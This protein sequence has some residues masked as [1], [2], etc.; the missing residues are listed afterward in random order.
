VNQPQV[1]RSHPAGSRPAACALA[2]PNAIGRTLEV[3]TANGSLNGTRT[4]IGTVK[5]I[6]FNPEADPRLDVFLPAAQ[7][8]WTSGVIFVKGPAP[9]AAFSRAAQP[10]RRSRSCAGRCSHSA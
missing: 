6:A 9:P 10:Q 2:W 1:D 8:A 4:V 5:P 7:A 3:F